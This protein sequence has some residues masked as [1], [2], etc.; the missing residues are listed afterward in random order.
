MMLCGGRV[1]VVVGGSGGSGV[2]AVTA[3]LT[4]PMGGTCACYQICI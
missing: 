1:D 3:P 4:G 2:G